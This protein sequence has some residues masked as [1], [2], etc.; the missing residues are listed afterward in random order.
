M[1]V[2]SNSARGSLI[3]VGHEVGTKMTNV[4]PSIALFE[5]RKQLRCVYFGTTVTIQIRQ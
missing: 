3:H 2:R 5:L 4:V 1:D